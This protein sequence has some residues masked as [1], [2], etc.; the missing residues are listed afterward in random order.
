MNDWRPIETIP[1]G[2]YVLLWFIGNNAPTIDH[3]WMGGWLTIDRRSI[4]DGQ[5]ARPLAWFSHWKEGPEPPVTP[6]GETK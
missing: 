4:W 6:E 5:M 3:Q 2:K 1:A